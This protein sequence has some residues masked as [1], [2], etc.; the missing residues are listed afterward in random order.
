MADPILLLKAGSRAAINAAAGNDELIYR[1]IYLIADEGR[2]AV[3]MEIDTYE[4][5]VKE[6]ELATLQGEVDTNTALL[7]DSART[8]YISDIM[9][10]GPENLIVNGWGLLGDNRNFSGWEF[11]NSQAVVGGGS[12]R[13]PSEN[14][15]KFSDGYIPVDVNT[16]YEL[17]FFAKQIGTG[18]GARYYFG[19]A[20]YDIAGL[21]IS[22]WHYLQQAGTQTTLAVDL[23]DSDTTIT[24]TDSTNWYNG[25]VAHLRSIRFG[26]YVGPTGYQYGAYDYSRNVIRETTLGAYAEGGISGNVI[27]LVFPYSGPTIPAGTPIVNTQAGGTYIYLTSNHTIPTS[28]TEY[29]NTIGGGAAI[30]FFPGTAFV[31]FLALMNRNASAGGEDGGDA[32]VSGVT[33]SKNNAR[34][35]N[36]END[37]GTNATAIALNTTKNSYPSAD[38]TKVGYISVTQP[39]DLDALESNV[40]TNNSKLTA[41]ATNVD[42][43]GATMNTDTDVSANS[44]VVDEDDMSS[45]LATKVPTQ[46]SVKAFVESNK[47]HVVT[48]FSTVGDANPDSSINRVWVGAGEPTNAVVGD[49]LVD[50]T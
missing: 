36:L 38:A 1:E 15:T 35:S 8:E 24:L 2:L 21:E 47:G 4:A 30:Q 10:S 23:N 17:S 16:E 20:P 27:S 43:A 14:V 40:S 12:F 3:A 25:S 37:V 42:A 22:P 34:L 33:F 13:T 44:W 6:S 49:L 39:V 41:N 7:E 19:F 46:Q 45:D 5:F 11:D 28:W 48:T 26:N 29:K 9:Y 31:K 18:T 50:T 32:V